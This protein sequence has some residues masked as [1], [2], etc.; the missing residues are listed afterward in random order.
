MRC[1]YTAFTEAVAQLKSIGEVAE[2]K[3]AMPVDQL[4][5]PANDIAQ[6]IALFS[7]GAAAA[8]SP[9]AAVGG[10]TLGLLYILYEQWNSNQDV[11]PMMKCAK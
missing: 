9:A 1:G 10:G 3:N 7:T 4:V 11:A 5:I 8:V 6:L 2:I